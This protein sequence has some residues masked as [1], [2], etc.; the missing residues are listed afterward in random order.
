MLAERENDP[1]FPLSPADLKRV[2]AVILGY[3]QT[4]GKNIENDFTKQSFRTPILN[5]MLQSHMSH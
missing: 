3:T 2:H 4:K 1:N 5:K